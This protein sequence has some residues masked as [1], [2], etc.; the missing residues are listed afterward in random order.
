MRLVI[1]GAVLI[2]A[3]VGFFL[4]MMGLAPQSNDPKALMEIVSQVSGIVVGLSVAL[5]AIG[6]IGRKV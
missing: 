5:I 3:A 1:A 4:Y 2:A 6:L